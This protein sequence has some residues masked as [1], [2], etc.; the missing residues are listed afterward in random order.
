VDFNSTRIPLFL[1][2]CSQVNEQK[3]EL[4]DEEEEGGGGRRRNSKQQVAKTI[5]YSSV[6]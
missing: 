2:F 3:E 6:L 4:E 1:F 5:H